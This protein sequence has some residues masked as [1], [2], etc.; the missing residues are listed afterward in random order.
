MKLLSFVPDLY[1]ALD[2]FFFFQAED[3][4]RDWSVTGVQTC[5]LPI[6]LFSSD[7]ERWMTL[8]PRHSNRRRPQ[9]VRSASRWRPPSGAAGPEATNA[10]FLRI[11]PWQSMQS[12]ST[13][14]RGS[15]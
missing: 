14:A 4:I 9:G 13:A 2:A 6:S 8:S 15:P 11:V 7:M 10:A 3:G 5:A 1:V 12:I